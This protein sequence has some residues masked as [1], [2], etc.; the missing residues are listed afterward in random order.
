[1]EGEVKRHFS[2]RRL[3]DQG[4]FEVGSECPSAAPDGFS[5]SILKFDTAELVHGVGEMLGRAPT[6]GEKVDLEL[7]GRFLEEF[8]HVSVEGHDVVTIVGPPPRRGRSGSASAC[9]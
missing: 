6:N 1:M 2:H 9:P 4:S 7:R 3:A 5:E 8:G